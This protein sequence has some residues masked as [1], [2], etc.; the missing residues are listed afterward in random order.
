[1]EVFIKAALNCLT[2]L[3]QIRIPNLSDALSRIM[4]VPRLIVRV[5]LF[6]LSPLLGVYFR[7][8]HCLTN[9]ILLP[10]RHKS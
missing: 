9:E 10:T 7:Q 4:F 2:V 8:Q 3:Q 5:L 6:C 1:M